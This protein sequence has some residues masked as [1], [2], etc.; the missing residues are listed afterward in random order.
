MRVTQ[1]NQTINSQ[2]VEMF[3]V[4]ISTMI[5]LCRKCELQKSVT[6]HVPKWPFDLKPSRQLFKM[7]LHLEGLGRLSKTLQAALSTIPY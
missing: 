4:K 1:S 5:K 2:D 6:K 3:C 7:D